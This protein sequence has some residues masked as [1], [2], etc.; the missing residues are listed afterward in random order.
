MNP[1]NNELYALWDSFLDAWPIQRLREMSLDEY[2][3]LNRDDAFVYWL[4]KR[5][6][7]LGSV[8][9]GSAFKWG[10]YRR[11]NTAKV[12]SGPGMASNPQYA[13]YDRYGDSPEEAFATVKAGLI[14]LAEAAQQ[15]DLERI[16]A[17]D[18][19]W[20]VVKWKI[21][22]LYQNRA[23]PKIFPVFREDWLF[24]AYLRISPTARA[25][26]ASR[27]VLY[28]ALAARY[29]GTGDV[30]DLAQRL[31]DLDAA[32]KRPRPA[33]IIPLDTYILER[34]QA[35]AFCAQPEVNP[36][37]VTPL[38][39]EHL[40]ELGVQGEDRLALL[41][42]QDIR[43]LG[44]VTLAEPGCHAWTQHPVELPSPLS[45]APARVEALPAEDQDSLW[46]ASP[47]PAPSGRP[48]IWKIAPGEGA[49]LWE[50]WKKGGYIAIGWPAFGDVSRLDEAGFR[51]LIQQHRDDDG[52]GARGPWQVWTFAHI[53]VG[54]RVVANRGTRQILGIGTV[55]GPYEHHP[56]AGEYCHRLPVRWDDLTPRTTWQPRWFTTLL[57]VAPDAFEAMLRDEAVDDEPSAEPEPPKGGPCPEPE[58]VI[59][60]G[61][62]GTGKTYAVVERAL[63]ILLGSAGLDALPLDTRAVQFRKLQHQGR[64]EMVTFHPSYGYEEFVEGLRPVLHADAGGEVRYELHPGVFKRI[65]LRA[66]AEG[67]VKKGGTTEERLKRVAEALDRHQYS[68]ADFQFTDQ[69]PPYV[70]IVDEI[71]RANIS[72][73]LGELITLL[74]ADKRLGAENELKLPLSSS[75][76]HRFAVPPNLHIIGTMNTADRSI[77]LLDVAL[78][79]RFR[80]EEML[81]DVEVIKGELGK[82]GV[83]EPL[84]A[85][86]VDLFVTLND[87]IRFLFDRDHQIGHAYFLKIRTIQDVKTLFSDRIIPLLQEYFYGAWDKVSAVLGCPR[88]DD[89][90]PRRKGP[91]VLGTDKKRSYREPLIAVRTLS[92][93]SALGY[94]DDDLEDR[95]VFEVSDLLSPRVD[96]PVERLAVALLGVLDL[97]EATWKARLAALC[98]PPADAP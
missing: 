7:K 65:A 23:D 41:V 4:E 87:R 64:V 5:T 80:F 71:N 33:W 88:D 47:A 21:A 59:L 81:P 73:V 44:V 29:A 75:P 90:S 51:A 8:W 74:E 27:V 30:F 39:D 57:P 78:R 37:D 24:R 67:L 25:R 17:L 12:I 77:A 9:G 14:Q 93:Q 79:R 34:D 82:R 13:W 98:P 61:P 92:A 15:G 32:E 85:L 3:N 84:V 46:A 18:V 52:Y 10:V 94:A 1:R 76:Q 68:S 96:A 11:Q 45:T 49:R 6:E 16:E 19:C 2:T 70:L 42:G 54:S 63:R 22:F 69:T 35:L 38:L 40:A 43:A 56:E 55:T 48:R 86:V 62:P 91:S 72:R 89:G 53:P 31:L 60:Y 50:Q 58:S 26:D 28:P 97:D 66:A 83:P 20:P 36:E 95:L